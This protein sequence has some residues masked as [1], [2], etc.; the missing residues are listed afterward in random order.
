VTIFK[1]PEDCA[2]F[3]VG[4]TS[5]A[6]M[7]GRHPNVLSSFFA[8]GDDFVVALRHAPALPL[9]RPVR[10]SEIL[11]CKL[12]PSWLFVSESR[13][14]RVPYYTPTRPTIY[15]D[16]A[17]KCKQMPQRP[18]RS[19]EL[20]SVANQRICARLAFADLR[21]IANCHYILARKFY[22]FAYVEFNQG[23]LSHFSIYPVLILI[24][25]KLNQSRQRIL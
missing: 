4:L 22:L 23:H 1:I 2:S 24:N 17:F 14:P 12:L 19:F 8:L 5:K 6:P 3:T 13:A 18:R 9:T 16:V 21:S 10:P 25:S 7:P 20:G 15:R 11:L